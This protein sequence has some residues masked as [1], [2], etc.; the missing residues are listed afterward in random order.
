MGLL[1][2]IWAGEPLKVGLGLLTFEGGFELFYT[3][4]EKS[5][6]VMGLLGIAN[7]LVALAIA[8][9]VSAQESSTPEEGGGEKRV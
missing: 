2:A 9:L 1:T 5:L 3:T 6:S 8:Y 7:L 4:Q